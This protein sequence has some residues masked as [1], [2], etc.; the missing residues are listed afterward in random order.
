MPTDVKLDQVNGNYLVLEADVV[1][2]TATDLLLDAP[3]R[4]NGGGPL[5][6]ALVHDQGDGL[7]VNFA[8]DY[9]G[10]VTLLNVAEIVPKPA[11]TVHRFVPTLVIRGGISYEVQ[12]FALVGGPAPRITVNLAEEID[13]LQTQIN[14]LSA[15]IQTLEKK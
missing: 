1:K 3:S 9:P 13:K 12:G 8:G 10:G 2:A 6:R 11:T 14:D 7:T 5:R 4:R 15:R